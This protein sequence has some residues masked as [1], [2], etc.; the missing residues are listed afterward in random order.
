MI[1]FHHDIKYFDYFSSIPTGGTATPPGG[2]TQCL[3]ATAS[4]EEEGVHSA[5]EEAKT[6][7]DFLEGLPQMCPTVHCVQPR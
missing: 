5:V 2:A 6:L 1:V 3:S 7:M 4:G